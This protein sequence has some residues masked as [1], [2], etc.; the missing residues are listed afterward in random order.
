MKKVCLLL[1]N[2]FEAVEASVFTDVFGFPIHRSNT[3]TFPDRLCA[4]GTRSFKSAL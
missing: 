4:L 3:G 2:G 1:P